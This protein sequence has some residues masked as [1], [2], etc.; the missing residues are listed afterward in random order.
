LIVDLSTFS[1]TLV[2]VTVLL[3]AVSPNLSAMGAAYDGAL[4]VLGGE[5]DRLPKSCQIG[6]VRAVLAVLEDSESGQIIDLR[7]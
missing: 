3:G 2:A 6:A 4:R 7:C 1:D 5:T